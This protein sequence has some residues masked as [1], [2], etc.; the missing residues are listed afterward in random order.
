MI[1]YALVVLLAL[2]T[3]ARAGAQGEEVKPGTVC[4]PMHYAGLVAGISQDKHV[5][6][7]LGS[8][9]Y[10]PREDEGVRY[11]VNSRRTATLRVAT[12]TDRIVGEIALE[13]GVNSSLSKAEIPK[14]VSAYFL[15]DEGF[16]NW[17]ALK[18]G[19]TKQAA[20]ENLGE[21]ARKEGDDA[22]TYEATCSCEIPN[23]MTIYFAKDKVVRVV[24][25]AP[26]G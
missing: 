11:F 13:A 9:V 4:W 20:L 6:R 15:T 16:G 14:A 22:W 17:H 19:S 1:R 25:S 8:G 2:L 26:P 18:L 12:Y 5:V 7:L 21:P 10:R 3:C 23:Y 24:F